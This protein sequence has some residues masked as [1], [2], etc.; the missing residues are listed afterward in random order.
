MCV[1]FALELTLINID[2]V[3]LENL[4]IKISSKQLQQNQCIFVQLTVIVLSQH[5]LTF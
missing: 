1:I 2:F 3:A 4:Q 5:I